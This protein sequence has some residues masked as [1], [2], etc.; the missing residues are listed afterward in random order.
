[1]PSTSSACS[2]N[3]SAANVGYEKIREL[4]IYLDL[5]MKW[6]PVGGE[7]EIST[8]KRSAICADGAADGELEEPW[9]S[10][11]RDIVSVLWGMCLLPAKMSSS[12]GAL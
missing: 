3:S 11:L 6:L 2:S 4:P 5:K 7:S 8:T 1:M 12:V 10:L 9:I